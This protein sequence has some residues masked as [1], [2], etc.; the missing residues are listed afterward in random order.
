[1]VMRAS[2]IPLFIQIEAELR[3]QI[4]TGDLGSLARVP[5][6]TE[7]AS[8]FSVSRMTARKALDRLVADGMLFRQPGKGT[9]VAP[10]KIAHGASQG[11]SF[12]GAMRAQ[13]LRCST[14]VL[15]AGLIP[16]P[17]NVARAL[18]L[19]GG[20][21]LIFMRRLR[22]IE[23]APVAIHMSYLPGRLTAIL[24]ADLTGSLS[25][26]MASVGVRVERSDDT[27]E[28]VAAAAIEARLLHVLP[29]SPLIFIRGTAY[30]SA[31]EPVRYSE[32]L[33]PGERWRFGI[34]ATRQLDLRPELKDAAGRD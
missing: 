4:E 13:G 17:S 24:D 29:G 14:R 9:F 32:A 10:P 6:E 16:A 20:S 7:L 26:L 11:L 12:S 8:Q 5:S 33:Y 31:N 27:V 25:Q 1:M 34:E 23:K 2:P 28:A 22:L 18:G 19:A 30:S 3:G 21:S 15:E